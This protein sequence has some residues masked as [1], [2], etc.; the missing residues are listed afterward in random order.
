MAM[1]SE[2]KTLSEE[3]GTRAGIRDLQGVQV[4]AT[5]WWV[6]PRKTKGNTTFLFLGGLQKTT[7][8]CLCL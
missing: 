8:R 3:R 4:V 7:P 6:L 5:F 1:A 2:K